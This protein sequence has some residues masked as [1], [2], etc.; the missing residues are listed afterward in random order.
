MVKVQI[1]LLKQIANSKERLEDLKTQDIISGIDVEDLQNSDPAVESVFSDESTLH[2]NFL[3]T[4]GA[5]F[6]SEHLSLGKT[7]MLESDVYGITTIKYDKD[8][9]DEINNTIEGLL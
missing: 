6:V 1:L 3:R 2:N 8:I 4:V 9:Y 7:I 5:V